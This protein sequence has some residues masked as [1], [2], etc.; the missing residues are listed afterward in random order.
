MSTVIY[1]FS[2]TGNSLKFAEKIAERCDGKLIHIS[3]KIE[4]YEKADKIGFVFPVYAWG[5]P[6]IVERFIER[7]G[8]PEA[9][10]IFTALTHGGG[11]GG[12]VTGFS[13]LLGKEPDGY[14]EIHMPDNYFPM[15]NPPDDERA[16]TIISK[17]SEKLIKICEKI[18]QGEK[19]RTKIPFIKK[20]LSSIMHKTFTANLHK[21]DKKFRTT[22][23]CTSCGICEKLCPVD[24]IKIENGTPKWLGKC[25]QC[26]ACF[27]WCPEKAIEF[28]RST[29]K[30]NR[31]H[32]PDIT[33]QHYLKAVTGE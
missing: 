5:P 21:T 1:W 24:N 22:E 26:F 30:T 10:Y 33:L 6:A 13:K 7:V 4:N 18:A 29:E 32:N 17:S 3:D 14:F 16:G 9:E 8:A 20:F 19:S 28:G 2:G 27:H 12:T 23:K 15:K 25:E 11:P 31:Y